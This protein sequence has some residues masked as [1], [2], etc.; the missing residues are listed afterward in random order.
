MAVLPYGK[1][2]SMNRPETPARL[3]PIPDV[4]SG[5]DDRKLAIDRVGIKGLRY[6]LSFSDG[7]GPL[8]MTVATCGVYVALPED[9]KG[10]HMSRLVALLEERAM[11]DAAALSMAG[12]RAFIDE[13]LVRLRAAARDESANL[14]PATI[15]AVEARATMGEVVGALEDVFGRYRE[16][17]AF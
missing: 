15:A 9:R 11:P 6:P 7:G 8:Q 2:E 4:Q 12:L 13:L 10:T 1:L 3:M 17:A 14:M 16:N 5:H